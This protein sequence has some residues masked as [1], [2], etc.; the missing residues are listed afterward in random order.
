M[1]LTVS[2][3]WLDGRHVVFGEVLEGY[4]IVDKI[5][6]VPKGRGDKPEKAVTIVKSGELE[7]EKSE[8]EDKGSR[9][10]L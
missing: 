9:D 7:M 4:D 3:R 10:E 1:F 8:T 6:N 5:Q 2:R